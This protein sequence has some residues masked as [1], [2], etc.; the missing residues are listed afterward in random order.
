MKIRMKSAIGVKFDLPSDIVGGSVLVDGADLTPRTARPDCR[1]VNSNVLHSR[2]S[3]A[4]ASSLVSERSHGSR[5][6]PSSRAVG[7]AVITEAGGVGVGEAMDG[8]GAKGACVSLRGDVEAAGAASIASATRG[9]RDAAGSRD[10]DGDDGPGWSS[11]AGEATSVSGGAELLLR[12][13][14]RSR[15]PGAVSLCGLAGCASW[16]GRAEV[17]GFLDDVDGEGAVSEVPAEPSE[18][19]LSANATGSEIPIDPT[20]SASANAP[21]RPICLA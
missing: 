1:R 20:P 2:G 17:R 11:L 6:G 16:R 10:R 12:A 21:T 4:G 5:C 13:L 19:V 8:S 18:P 15:G 7:G 9:R 14:F 3:A